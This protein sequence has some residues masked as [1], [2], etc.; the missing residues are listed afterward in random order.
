MRNI[1]QFLVAAPASGSGKTT[2]SR[3]LMALLAKQGLSVQP[4]KCGPDYIDTKYHAAVCGRPSLNLDLFMSSSE[5][6]QQLYARHAA[7]AD[8]ALAEGMMGLFDGYERDRGSSADVAALLSLPVV[9]VVD[10]KSAAYSVAALLS[11]FVHFRANVH[12]AGVIFNRVGSARHY[13]MLCEVCNDLHIACYGYLPKRQQL[14]QSSRYLGLD[15]SAGNCGEADELVALLEEHVDWRRLLRDTMRPLP[16][17]A[18]YAS[19]ARAEAGF[20]KILVARNAEAFSFIYQEHLDEL[21]RLGKVQFFDP[22]ANEPIPQDTAL[23][24]L[25]GGYPEKHA[26]ALAA[27]TIT[28]KSVQ[29]YAEA[30]GRVLAECG[31]LIYLSQGIVHNE[32]QYLA[33]GTA[34][35]PMAGVLPFTVCDAPERRKL[36]LGYRQ[37]DYNGQQLRGHEFHYTQFGPGQLPPTVAQVFDARRRPVPTPVFRY[38]NVIASYTHLYWGE[39]DLKKLF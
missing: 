19:P 24:Y 25:P 21:S 16:P 5:H 6:L 20:G 27:A 18:P 14:E 8:V 36:S 22:E 31:G 35:D 28:R 29:A 38:K 10:A 4:F 26:A 39:I 13:E 12:V 17:A 2:I 33:D 23:L 7:Q 1:P 32:E 30:G 37:F 11:G 34:C 9:L 15:F 3:G